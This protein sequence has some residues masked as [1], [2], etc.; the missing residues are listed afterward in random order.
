MN[1]QLKYYLMLWALCATSVS[2]T[3]PPHMTIYQTET[4]WVDLREWPS[5]YP[6][7]TNFAHP[8]DVETA[9]LRDLLHQIHY[10]HSELFSS[11]MGKRRPTFTDY[12]VTLLARELPK[13]F[14]QA[15]PEEVIDFRVRTDQASHLYTKGFCFIHQNEF[16]LIIQELQRATFDISA[17][18][19]RP[20]TIR[21]EFSPQSTQRMFTPSSRSTHDFPHWIITPIPKRSS[22]GKF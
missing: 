14:G 8:A 3:S 13:A 17:S 5:G 11:H 6:I 15:L 4:E 16:H 10:Q 2:C 19:A 22:Y 1:I 12:Q 18:L 7:L 9:Q 21:W 20:P